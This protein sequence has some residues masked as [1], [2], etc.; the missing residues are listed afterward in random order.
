MKKK[1]VHQLN[2]ALPNAK[3]ELEWSEVEQTG[4]SLFTGVEE[5]VVF[6]P[7]YT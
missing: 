1:D 4:N 5:P 7:G 6:R 2:E 3:Y